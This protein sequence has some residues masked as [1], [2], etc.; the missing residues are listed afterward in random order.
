MNI[1][2]RLLLTFTIAALISGSPIAQQVSTR[3]SVAPLPFGLPSGLNN[4]GLIGGQ[5]T[6]FEAQLLTPQGEV[7]GLGFIGDVLAISDSGIAVGPGHLGD[8]PRQHC[9]RWR[10]ADGVVDLT[11][12]PLPGNCV[13]VGVNSSGE[14]VGFIGRHS[15]FWDAE[16][17]PTRIDV[18]EPVAEIEVRDIN[19]KGTVVGV[20][21]RGEY[22]CA[23]FV[24]SQAAGGVLLP[25]PDL[26]FTWYESYVGAINNHGDIAGVVHG[27]DPLGFLHVVL[28]VWKANGR[29]LTRVEPGNAVYPQIVED[30]NDLGWVLVNREFGNETH[31]AVWLSSADTL[32]D[33]SELTGLR[34]VRGEKLNNRG[35]VVGGDG[36]QGYA[37]TLKR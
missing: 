37:W 11:P 10:E 4:P 36:S 25:F 7:V 28:T 33:L 14:V 27:T 16:G 6:S 22:C 30:I 32:V 31:A 2:K 35:I 34:F 1:S 19:E 9:F 20:V 13:A 3:V 15:Y 29:I 26:P 12:S 24:W 8:P 5:A 17:V 18:P 21:N 23:G